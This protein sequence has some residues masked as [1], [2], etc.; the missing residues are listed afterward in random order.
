MAAYTTKVKGPVAGEPLSVAVIGGGLSGLFAARS[1]KDHGHHVKVFEKTDRPGGRIATQ[2]DGVHFFDTGAQYFTV[3]DPRLK[4]YVQSWQMDGI[5]QPWK[6]KVQ[7]IKKGRLSDEKQVTERWVGVPTMEA[8]AAHLAAAVEI[9]LNV[10]V[11]SVTKH[12]GQWKLIDLHNRVYEPYD[13]VIVAVPPPRATGLLRSS[14]ALRRQVAEV[15]MQPCLAVMAAFEKPLDLS[16]D[17][18]FIHQSSVRWAARNNSKPRRPAPECWVFHGN[19]EWSQKVSDRKDDQTTGRSLIASF[20]ESIGKPFIDPICQK[21]RFWRSA[22]AVN[23]LNLGCLWDAEFN[24]GVCGDWCQMSRV[25][26]AALSGMAMAGKIL[27]MA[28]KIQP[29]VQAAAE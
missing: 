19:A 21:T 5:V 16:F 15:K 9:E 28:A 13:V 17:A 26:G 2:T 23:P 8:L 12:N 14:P 10:T 24:I 25:E 27:G 3:R 29:N 6:G 1:I 4:R 7:V 18:A 11:E 20:F 22:A